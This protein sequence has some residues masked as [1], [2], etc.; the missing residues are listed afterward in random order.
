MFGQ[1]LGSWDILGY[2]RI[3]FCSASFFLSFFLSH[4][5]PQK[6]S[7]K[8]SHLLHVF[9]ARLGAASLPMNLCTTTFEAFDM[10]HKWHKK[11]HKNG[12]TWSCADPWLVLRK[13]TGPMFFLKWQSFRPSKQRL[14]HSSNE[15]DFGATT[16]SYNQ[17]GSFSS[18][19]WKP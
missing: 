8:T 17:P 11:M 5:S 14:S 4:F 2:L 15:Q 18:W 13:W 7:P 3:G 1:N 10:A 16:K 19:T 6:T 12:K 9:A